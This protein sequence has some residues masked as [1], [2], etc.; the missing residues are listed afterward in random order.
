MDVKLVKRQGISL[1]VMSLESQMSNNQQSIER[2]VDE[3]ETKGVM[4]LTV[5][6]LVSSYWWV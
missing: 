1:E 3:Q 6:D 4:M 5:R 2:K